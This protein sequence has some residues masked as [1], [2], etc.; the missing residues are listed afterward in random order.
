MS[1]EHQKY[2]ID[3]QK[4]H[5]AAYALLRG[6]S[7]VRTYADEGI[8]GLSLRN[9]E[10][11]KMLLADVVSG[12]AEFEKIL[13]YDVSRW[14]RFQDP[15]QAAHYEFLCRE[16]GVAVEYCAEPFE[17]D[18]SLTN[19][20]VKQL[21]RAM[22][23]EYSRELSVKVSAAQWN[24]ARRGHW[25]GG[26]PG[27]G[28]RRRLVHANGSLGPILAF[29]ECKSLMSDHVVIAT[30]PRKERAVVRRIY[31]L[32]V[33][34]GLSRAEISRT[35]N[36]EGIAAENGAPW[37]PSRV[38]QVLTNEKY[39]G[40]LVF[41]RTAGRLTQ[42]TRRRPRAAWLRLRGLIRP[43][44]SREIFDLA[45]R[46]IACRCRQLPDELMLQ[47]LRDLLL[48]HGR[49]NSDLIDD[50]ESLPC[51]DIYRRRF[52]GLIGA[53]ERIGYDPSG[54]ATK[55]ASIVRVGAPCR[56]RNRKVQLSPEE[57]LS[58]L[59]K[60]LGDVG[61]LSAQILRDSPTTP[62]ADVYCRVF[63]SMRRTYELVGY[64]PTKKQQMAMAQWETR[65]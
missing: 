9:R 12:R 35:L 56:R 37:S 57:M 13:T 25:V 62:G 44:V 2:S 6:Y 48:E 14:G 11:L 29:G 38:R 16:A 20:L 31:R 65:R 22:A 5:I 51:A 15:D 60:L 32:F 33:I 54:R 3:H 21:K 24:L 61:Y 47:G 63:G 30:G 39:A 18:G 10:G 58:R 55:A 46:N 34:G 45:Q 52:G 40:V 23:A 59:G 1:T 43:I 26:P 64:Q 7:V 27:F 50:A 19:T 8:S 4:V 36:D 42:G 41:G 28:F 53:Y 17:N 49:L